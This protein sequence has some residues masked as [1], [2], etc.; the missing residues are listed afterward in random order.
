MNKK[1][2]PEPVVGALIFNPRG[3]IFLMTS[4]KWPGQYVVPGG[5]I[6]LGET[7]IEALIREV[8]EETG[9]KVDTVEFLEL[10]EAIFSEDFYEKKRHFILIDFKCRV[11]GKQL[12]QLNDEGKEYIWTDPKEAL[13]LPLNSLTRKAVLKYLEKEKISEKKAK[14]KTSARPRLVKTRRY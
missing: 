4:F 3:E 2:Y 13:K 8:K 12:V 10:Q 1:N 14:R 5:H 11:A 7:A 9:L 6:E